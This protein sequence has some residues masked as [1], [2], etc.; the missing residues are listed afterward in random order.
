MKYSHI[1]TKVMIIE[2]KDFWINMW[3]GHT[4]YRRLYDF[5]TLARE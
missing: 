2:T 4:V 5:N 3:Y 1:E